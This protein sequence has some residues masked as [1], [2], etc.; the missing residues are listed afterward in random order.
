MT[1][2]NIHKSSFLILLKEMQSQ[3]IFRR[4][5]IHLFNKYTYCIPILCQVLV[6]EQVRQKLGFNRAHIL[7]E[8]R[9]DKKA[10]RGSSRRGAA[11]TTPTRNHEV[12]GLI[13]GLIH[14]VKD[15]ALQ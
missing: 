9:V 15:P 1:K 13:P 4:I 11:E 14:L 8:Q 3:N 10:S 6:L 12:A 2:K 5:H 7:L